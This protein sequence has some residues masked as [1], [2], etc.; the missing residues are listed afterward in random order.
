MLPFSLGTLP[1]NSK[2]EAGP[3]C[4]VI[5]DTSVIPHQRITASQPEDHGEPKAQ[6]ACQVMTAPWT[7][8]AKI[9]ST[10]AWLADA[11]S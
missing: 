1:K 11:P 9:Y 7:S 10:S 8:L 5:R 4:Q 3:T 2:K 6:T